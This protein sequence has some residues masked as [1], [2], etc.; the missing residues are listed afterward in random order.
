M[1]SESILDY[2]IKQGL[3]CYP[4][5]EGELSKVEEQERSE[6]KAK[7]NAKKNAKAKAKAKNKADNGTN[8]L[9]DDVGIEIDKDDTTIPPPISTA[10]PGPSKSVEIKENKKVTLLLK[11]E[12]DTFVEKYM[13]TLLNAQGNAEDDIGLEIIGKLNDLKNHLAG[14]SRD[15]RLNI[16]ESVTSGVLKSWLKDEDEEEEAEK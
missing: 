1:A 15:N 8:D 13:N 12:E 4:A 16:A 11:E 10:S 6:K 14:K 2:Y 9:S 3:D 5:A 7:I